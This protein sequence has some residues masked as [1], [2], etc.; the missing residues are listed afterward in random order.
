M[1]A[2]NIFF[3]VEFLAVMLFSFF[4]LVAQDR[5]EDTFTIETL[6][7]YLLFLFSFFLFFRQIDNIYH[8]MKGLK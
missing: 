1:L 2:L 8:I 6:L 4:F 7:F 5:E 3:L